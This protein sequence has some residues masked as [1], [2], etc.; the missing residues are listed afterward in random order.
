MSISRRCVAALTELSRRLLALTGFSVT[1]LK[2]LRLHL[3]RVSEITGET[4]VLN[5]GSPA[6]HG[7]KY[8][9]SLTKSYLEQTAGNADIADVS[10]SQRAAASD[11]QMFDVPQLKSDKKKHEIGG[12]QIE[13]DSLV[14]NYNVEN[15][16]LGKVDNPD[17]SKLGSVPGSP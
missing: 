15:A 3:D 2:C 8:S 6:I 12:G 16:L 4:K 11:I 5:T 9:A 13:A 1:A 17:R 7:N 10:A 14:S